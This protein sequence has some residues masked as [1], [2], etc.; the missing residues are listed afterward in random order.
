M[1]L[2]GSRL[3]FAANDVVLGRE[4]W[5]GRAAILA[6]RPD[7][8]V[9]DLREDVVALGLPQG[10][11]QSL[12]AKLG[13]VETA[14]ARARGTRQAIRLLDA[15]ER[16]VELK[17]PSPIPEAQAAD[18]L[19]FA[20]EIESLLWESAEPIVAPVRRTLG[21]RSIVLDEPRRR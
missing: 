1:T 12:L 3:F 16:E 4:L 11:E 6:H 8:A 21:E 18:L 19:E 17:T 14:L 20:E 2:A 15:F 13:A 10:I 9:S 5:A 7:R